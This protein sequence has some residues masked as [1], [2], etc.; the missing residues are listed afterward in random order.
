MLNAVYGGSLLCFEN[1]GSFSR[2]CSSVQALQQYLW[3]LQPISH[4]LASCLAGSHASSQDHPGDWH[5]SPLS[6]NPCVAL[7]SLL[8]A[9]ATCMCCR[10][11]RT[12]GTAGLQQ[13]HMAAPCCSW[14]EAIALLVAA[15]SPA[16]LS[17]RCWP[18]HL[19][20]SILKDERRDACPFLSLPAPQGPFCP[21]HT[22]CI[23]F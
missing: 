19:I 5:P 18:A 15:P 23:A 10:K 4:Q 6:S 8:A 21:K 16:G 20:H 13:Q 12:K 9:S 17:T 2:A 14:K 22:L 1:C 11:V 3:A 7:R